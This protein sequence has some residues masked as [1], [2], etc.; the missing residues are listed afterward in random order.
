MKIYKNSSRRDHL[1][2][3][4]D[5]L[6]YSSKPT[7]TTYKQVYDFGLEHKEDV[8]QHDFT[9]HYKRDKHTIYNEAMVRMKPHLRK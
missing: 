3:L 7:V 5:K 4:F 8:M 2:E 1:A 9:F 6:K